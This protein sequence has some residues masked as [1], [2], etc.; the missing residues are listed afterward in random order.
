[1]GLSIH[2][3][4]RLKDASTLKLLI[5]EV[6]DIATNNS[7]EYFVFEE[8]FPNNAFSKKLEIENLYGLMIIPP[9]SEPFCLSFLSNGIMCGIMNFNIFQNNNNLKESDLQQSS[10]K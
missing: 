1:M 7:W 8:E 3:K 5:E 4:G 9:E 6:K 2:Y 10:C